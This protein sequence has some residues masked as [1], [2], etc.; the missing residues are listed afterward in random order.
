M[1][2]HTT[3]VGNLQGFSLAPNFFRGIKESPKRVDNQDSSCYTVL[4]Y[5]LSEEFAN[6][7]GGKYGSTSNISNDSSTI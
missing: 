3:G 1:P 5:D 2:H 4:T 6:P 7:L